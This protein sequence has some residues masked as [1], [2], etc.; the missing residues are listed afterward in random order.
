MSVNIFTI[1]WNILVLDNYLN[2][3]KENKKPEKRKL[4]HGDYVNSK[5]KSNRL[6]IPWATT[7][8]YAVLTEIS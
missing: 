7:F 5:K 4:R 2:H 1:C 3:E 6:G 8:I